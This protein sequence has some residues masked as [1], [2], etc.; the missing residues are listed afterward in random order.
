MRTRR[1]PARIWNALGL[2]ALAAVGGRA[3]AQDEV[4]NYRTPVLVVETEGHHAPVRAIVWNP[5]G[6]LFSAGFD[7][8]VKFWELGDA[9]RPARSIRPPVWRGP[10]GL[11][12]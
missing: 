5:A 2:A 9:S 1:Q 3:A 11:I 4:R 10:A 8:T 7:K 6:G 12:F